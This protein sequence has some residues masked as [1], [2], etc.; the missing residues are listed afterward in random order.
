MNPE[1]EET[2]VPHVHCLGA[3][4]LDRPTVVEALINQNATCTK[5]GNPFDNGDVCVVLK[6]VEHVNCDYPATPDRDMRAAAYDRI[7]AL[8]PVG[9]S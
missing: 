2:G 1:S 5:C 6:R 9:E 4:G 3:P 7:R 8:H